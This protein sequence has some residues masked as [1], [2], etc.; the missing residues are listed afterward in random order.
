MCTRDGLE[1]GGHGVTRWK[2]S[3]LFLPRVMTFSFRP[4]P[5]TN[6]YALYIPKVYTLWKLSSKNLSGRLPPPKRQKAINH[7]LGR[8]FCFLFLWSSPPPPPVDRARNKYLHTITGFGLVNRIE[9]KTRFLHFFLFTSWRFF[10]TELRC[11]P[12]W[13]AHRYGLHNIPTTNS[14][15]NSVRPS[16]M[17][18]IAGQMFYSASVTLP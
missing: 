16:T 10:S 2:W 1:F 3:R 12:C 18:P 13:S 4:V 15:V 11:I 7:F 5:N 6:T 8:F 17:M 9:K 14:Q